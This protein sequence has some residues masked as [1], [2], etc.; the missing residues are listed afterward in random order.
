MIA[1]GELPSPARI[2]GIRGNSVVS[3]T[4]RAPSGA[5]MVAMTMYLSNRD[6]RPTGYEPGEFLEP[7]TT[8]E[9]QPNRGA[10]EVDDEDEEA[11]MT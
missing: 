7:P 4:R 1:S 11:N 3:R 2:A 8:A 6:V 10:P 5:T 9:V